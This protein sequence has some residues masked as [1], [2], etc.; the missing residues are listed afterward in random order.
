MEIKNYHQATTLLD[1]YETFNED[2]KNVI[3]GGGLWIKHTNPTIHT[4]IDLSNLG[5]NQITEYEDYIEI[6][7]M[8]TLRDFEM[9]HAI[10]KLGGGFLF[11]G[12]NQIMGVGF[13]NLATVGGSIFGRYP[14]SDL[15]TP[16]LAL[17]TKLVFFMN[18]EIKLLDY[19]NQ[20]GK[21]ND[22]LVSIQIK[23]TL[24][25][26]F[27]KKVS[28]TQ[29]AFSILNIAVFKQD[30]KFKIVLGSRPGISTLALE[31][32]DLLDNAVDVNAEIILE[33]AEIAASS[34]RFGD[35]EDATEEYRRELARVYV[36]RGLQ[37]VI[38]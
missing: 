37:E 16:L 22:I 33:A 1:A 34:I 35:N 19:L 2:S 38:S 13:R 24:G 36:R 9:H 10:Q 7:A 11:Q 3:V 25:K 31:A 12:T 30:Q 6:G 5:L 21:N 28:N 4:M 8:V 27:F 14:F 15:I 23:K 29:L 17:E 26:G 20:K 18:G 32:I